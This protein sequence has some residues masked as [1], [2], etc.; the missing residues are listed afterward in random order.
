MK[1]LEEPVE[2]A[3]RREKWQRILLEFYEQGDI[4]SLMAAAEMLNQLWHHQTIISQW[5]A[6]EAADNLGEAWDLSRVQ[7]QQDHGPLC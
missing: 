1:P 4:K 6:H 2:L 3:L 7:Q 5:L